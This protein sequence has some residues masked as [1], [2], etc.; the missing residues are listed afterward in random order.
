MA[1]PN[2]LAISNIGKVNHTFH[3]KQ[4]WWPHPVKVTRLVPSY[5]I[6]KVIQVGGQA[7]SNKTLSKRDLHRGKNN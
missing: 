7:I 4:P 3:V 2:T 6:G 5:K 1:S